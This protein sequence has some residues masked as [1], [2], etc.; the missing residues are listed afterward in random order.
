MKPRPQRPRKSPAS[1]GRSLATLARRIL[2]LHY[3]RFLAAETR[4]RLGTDPECVHDLRVAARRMRAALRCFAAALPRAW[5]RRTLAEL[6]WIARAMSRLRDLEVSLEILRKDRRRLP[7]KCRAGADRIAVRLESR[8]GAA[9]RQVIEAMDSARGRRLGATLGRFFRRRGAAPAR[10]APDPA[11]LLIGRHRK[12]RR[13]LREMAPLPTAAEL[14]TLRIQLKKLRYACEFLAGHYGG[15]VGELADR[16]ARIQDVLGAHHDEEVLSALLRRFRAPALA[17]ALGAL[18]QRRRQRLLA[19]QQS[20]ARA[21]RKL[22]E[23]KLKRFF[24]RLRRAPR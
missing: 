14:H 23:A 4:L 13:L 22:Q 9:Q 11:D 8:R 7:P 24:A 12:V 3:R 21:L 10:R 19:L 18:Q 5:G 17:P 2:R 6:Q 1:D 15:P 20:C 16:L